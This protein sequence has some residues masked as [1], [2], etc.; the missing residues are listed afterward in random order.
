MAPSQLTSPRGRCDRH[1]PSERLAP[2]VGMA[3]RRPGQRRLAG[4]AGRVD[5]VSERL[6]GT[7]MGY[8]GGWYTTQL[9][10]AA[11]CSQFH[12]EEFTIPVN[13]EFPL[14]AL[15]AGQT[16]ETVAQYVS[17]A[18][19][20]AFATVNH[21]STTSVPGMTAEKFETTSNGEGLYEAGTKVY[22]YAINRGGRSFVVWTSAHPGESRFGSW[23]TI[24]DQAITTLRFL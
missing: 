12:P 9:T 23:K 10:P 7:S 1:V 20:A 5:A 19:D 3:W 15:N 4:T 17:G 14:T 24:V 18:T 2:A 8:P 13:G 6:R 22:G 11:K 21:R 16:D